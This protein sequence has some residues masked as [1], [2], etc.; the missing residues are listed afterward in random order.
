[1]PDRMKLIEN[2]F[3]V[4]LQNGVVHRDLKLENI[5]LDE[6]GNIKVCYNFPPVIYYSQYWPVLTLSCLLDCRF[7]F[8]QPLPQGQ[9]SSNILWQPA[10]CLP[11]DCERTTI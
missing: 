9:A 8:V 7:W 5:L 2:H 6:N 3:D 1:M 4:V 11:G 10:V